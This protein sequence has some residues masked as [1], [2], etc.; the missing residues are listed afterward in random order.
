MEKM[1]ITNQEHDAFVKSHPNGD[2]LQLTKWA[3][4]K[5]LTGWYARRIA[6]GRDGEIQGVAQLLFKKVPKLPYTLCYISRGFVVDYSNKEA[7]N[8]LLDSAKEIAKAEKAYA[9][10][11]DP[12]VEVDKGTDALQNLKAL[13]F[14]HKGFKEGLSKD[15]IQPRMTMITPIDKN[16]DELLNSFERRNRSKVRLALKRGTTV[17]RSDREGLKTFAE[18]MKI[19]GERDGFLTRDIS[20]FE[21]IYDALHEDGDAELFLVKLDPKEN[22]AKVNQELN[23]LHAEIAKWQQKMETSE[24]QAKKAQNMINDAQNKIAK[25]EDLKRDL[26]ALEKE[27]PEGIYLS[28]ALL[29]FAGSK[30][31]YLYGASSNEFRDFL[32]NHHMQY[33]MMKYA[34]EHGATTYDFGGTDN[35]PD[36]DSEHYGLWAFKKVWGTYLSEKI[37]EFDYVLNQPLY[38]LI[39]QVKPRLT[40]AKIK[41]SRKLKRK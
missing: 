20:Y 30:S 35:D 28:G 3:E 40:K 11:I 5:K 15:Y 24:K 8:A 23:E 10:K 41:I 22:I 9:I 27:H 25:N 33:T 17:E 4:I 39:E 7:L 36:K 32:P 31:Y 37:G 26:E 34:R 14:K 29:M 6:V 12:D 16:D 2:L 13:G 21:N 18:L 19:T 38:Q 1:H